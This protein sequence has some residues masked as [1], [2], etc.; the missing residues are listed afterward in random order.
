MKRDI[1]YQLKRTHGRSTYLYDFINQ[2]VNRQ[3]GESYSEYTT[4]FIRKAIILSAREARRFVYDLA[5]IAA[6]KNFT[7]GGFFDSSQRLILIDRRDLPNTF[8]LSISDR[9]MF[10][11]R[12]YEIVDFEEF[13]SN[14]AI[15]VSAL[16]DV[17]EYDPN[18]QAFID[19][20]WSGSTHE[21]Y[22][23]DEL[24]RA[25]RVLFNN[26]IPDTFY[27][28]P[29]C[30]TDLTDM[31][32]TLFHDALTNTDFVDAD[33][34]IIGVN[35][36]LKGD[37]GTKYLATNYPYDASLNLANYHISVMCTD[38][39]VASAEVLVGAT[40]SFASVKIFIKSGHVSGVLGHTSEP[41]NWPATQTE[42]HFILSST[43][44]NILRAYFNGEVQQ[45][46]VIVRNTPIPTTL[47][48]YI[49]VMNYIGTAFP[50]SSFTVARIKTVTLGEGLTDTQALALYTAINRFN[51]RLGRA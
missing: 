49:F 51:E 14:Y 11:D 17:E 2:T 46:T 41:V 6:A 7:Q 13:Q 25:I 34:N 29:C 33:Y 40:D 1:I 18:L 48:P 30:G 16:K 36:G 19:A 42:G 9:L 31:T 44:N 28:W 5:F 20:G 32:R 47:S 10:D 4:Y 39:D 8:E 26:N 21:K 3:T 15:V 24:V 12:R 22:A 50:V 37:A 45:T 35:G 38:I 27:L 43:A 23:L